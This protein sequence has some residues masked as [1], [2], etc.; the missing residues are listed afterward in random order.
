MNN[1]IKEYCRAWEEEGQRPLLFTQTSNRRG[2]PAA[3]PRG[4]LDGA[5][6]NG[7]WD[8]LLF[9]LAWN[10]NDESPP[11][12]SLENRF[13]RLAEG[14][15]WEQSMSSLPAPVAASI[16]E[17]KRRFPPWLG[18]AKVRGDATSMVQC[19]RGLLLD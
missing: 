18:R 9:S 7:E 1:G 17:P 8:H 13:L 6:A 3:C 14:R 4:D 5:W 11:P 10:E 2:S 15:A 16:G 19:L 12:P